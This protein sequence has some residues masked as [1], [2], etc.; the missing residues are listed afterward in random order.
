MPGAV[1]CAKGL[2][3]CRRPQPGHPAAAAPAWPPGL[4][5]RVVRRPAGDGH[6]QR[7]QPRRVQRRSAWCAGPYCFTGQAGRIRLRAYFQ[8]GPELRSVGV[9]RLHEV[10]TAFAMTVPKSQGSNSR[11]PCWCCPGRPDPLLSRSWS[12]PASPRPNAFLD[13]HAPVRPCWAA[14]WADHP[15][16]QPRCTEP[17][18]APT[19]PRR[20][21]RRHACQSWT[22]WR[23]NM[24]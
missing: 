21:P 12:P 24:T 20:H 22:A 18:P 5:R 19:P 9:S 1:P 16:G 11:T 3:R 13:G 10:E 6:A 17:S 7:R 4:V 23:W 8:D 2:G 14:R 15:A